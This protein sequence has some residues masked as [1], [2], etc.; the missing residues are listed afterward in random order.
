LRVLHRHEVVPRGQVAEQRLGVDAAQFLFPDRERHHWHVG[1]FQPGV[2]QFLVERHIGIAVDGGDH[3]GL[4][5][6]GKL[7]DVGHDRLVIAVAKRRVYLR[8]VRLR[9]ALGLE[10]R[11]QDLV[12]G[13]RINVIGTEQEPAFGG[14]ALFAHQVLDCGNGLLIGCCAGIEHVLRKLFAFVLHWV[15]Q[16]AVQF[17]EHRQTDLRDTEVQQPNTTATLS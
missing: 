10:E 15:E 1:R 7:L 3:R 8:D 2:A 17:L 11:S 14:A 5:G 4:A 6:C 9:H 13:A 12:G 16:Q